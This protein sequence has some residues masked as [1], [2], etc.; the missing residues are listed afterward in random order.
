MIGYATY[1]ISKNDYHRNNESYTFS[2]KSHTTM[3]F[4]SI[5]PEVI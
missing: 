2:F 4:Y 1:I 3:T 5:V